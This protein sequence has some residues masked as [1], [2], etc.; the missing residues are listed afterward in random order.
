MPEPWHSFLREIDRAATSHIATHCI[1]GFVVSLY[2]GL[3]RPTGDI[4]VVDVAQSSAKPWLSR[5]AGKGSALHEAPDL[6]SDRDRRGVPSS[7]TCS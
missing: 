4:D 6:S 7:S 5:T 2:Y 1:G 3:A